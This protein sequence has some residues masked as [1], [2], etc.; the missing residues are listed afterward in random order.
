MT[1]TTANTPNDPAGPWAI[2]VRRPLPGDDKPKSTTSFPR[3]VWHLLVAIKDAL[4]LIFLLL[5][6]VALVRSAVRTSEC[7]PAG[8]RGA[9]LVELDGIVSEQPCRDRSARRAVGGRPAQGNPG[10]RCR[11]RA[12]G[13][14]RRQAR[15]LGRARPRPLPRRR[16][17]VARRNRH[18]NRQGAREEKARARL[19]HRL[20]H[21]QLSG[22]IARQRNLGGQYRRRCDCRPG[23]IAP[24]S[25]RD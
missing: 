10:P 18:R 14:R 25:T 12:R 3:K 21:R 24:L 15:D 23:R 1:E 6:F 20:Y 22:S 4:A 16:A 5:F 13:C 19:C 17:G 9:L 8:Q 2:P 7:R 11:P